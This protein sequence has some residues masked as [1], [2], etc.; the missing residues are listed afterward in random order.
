MAVVLTNPRAPE[1]FRVVLAAGTVISDLSAITRVE[2]A[3]FQKFQTKSAPNF[4]LPT[5]IESK[6]AAQIV[7]RHDFVAGQLSRP[8]DY[9]VVASAFIGD[10]FVGRFEAAELLQIKNP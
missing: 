2:V 3:L 5:V 8:Y 7:A 9:A 4:V 6:T 1:C 10:S